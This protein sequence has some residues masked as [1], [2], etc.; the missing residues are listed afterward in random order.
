MKLK[1]TFISVTALF[2]L[3]TTTAAADTLTHG[4]TTVTM[5]FVTI[6]NPGNAGDTTALPNPCGAVAYTYYIGKY[7]VTADQWAAVRAADHN[8][9]NGGMW[10]GSQPTADTSWY[11]AAK[12]CNWLTTGSAATGVYSF[13]GSITNP[14][15]VTINRSYR[16]EAGMAYFLPTED[17]WYK[18]AYYDGSAGIYYDYPTGSNSVPDGIDYPGDTAFD[19]VFDDGYN[20]GHPNAVTNAGVAS[21]YGTIGQAGNVWEWE[22][23]AIDSSRGLRGGAWLDYSDDVATWCRYIGGIDPTDERGA[24]GF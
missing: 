10:S 20:Q 3:L 12:F 5:D 19:A 15:G 9:G 1:Q 17:E 8:V 21:P 24:I 6:G 16:N 23:T 7:E 4:T 22:E 13:T 18:A 14:T 2:G 11:E